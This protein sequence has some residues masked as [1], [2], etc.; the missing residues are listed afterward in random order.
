M[1][2]NARLQRLGVLAAIAVSH[3][4]LAGSAWRL[5]PD[6]TWPACWHSGFLSIATDTLTQPLFVLPGGHGHRGGDGPGGHVHH[7][8][9]RD[10]R[11]GAGGGRCGGPAPGAGR[12]GGRRG[13]LWGRRRRPGAHP[14]AHAGRPLF[15][16]GSRQ[17][18]MAYSWCVF[19]SLLWA[20]LFAWLRLRGN[21]CLQASIGHLECDSCCFWAAKRC[22]ASCLTC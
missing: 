21:T 6:G 5:P 2:P 10:A 17:T 20:V 15:S 1:T 18:L 19:C 3:Q 12:R 16:L 9:L 4:L 11:G 7:G 22:R 13:G 14:H 8:A